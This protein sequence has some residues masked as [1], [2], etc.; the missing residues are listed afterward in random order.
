M[1]VELRTERLVLRPIVL[2]DFECTHEYTT[3]PDVTK[4]MLNL[5]NKSESDTRNFLLFAETEW[6]KEHPDDYEFAI[7]HDGVHIG[8]INLALLGDGVYGMGWIINKLYQGH[9]YCT[10]AAKE[11]VHFAK[12]IGAKKIVA[13]CDWRNCASYHV[14]EKIG[15]VRTGIG[16]RAYC[17][18]RGIAHEYTY[19]LDDF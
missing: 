12:G 9:G 15:M 18:G 4:Y 11:M 2:K 5:P 17:D 7:F 1:Y 16:Q 10:E 8:G 3:D 13:R 14:M 19:T 6:K